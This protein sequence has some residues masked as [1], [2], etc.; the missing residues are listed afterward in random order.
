MNIT[1]EDYLFASAQNKSG[2]ACTAADLA[3]NP[4]CEFARQYCG[5]IFSIVIFYCELQGKVWFF[6]PYMVREYAFTDRYA[7]CT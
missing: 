5:G 4:T 6:V 1:F 2:P 3:A 7:A